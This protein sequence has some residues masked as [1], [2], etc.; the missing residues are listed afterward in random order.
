MFSFSQ[1]SNKVY[2]RNK[3]NIRFIDEFKK[4]I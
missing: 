4:K 1:A 2:Y 3:L